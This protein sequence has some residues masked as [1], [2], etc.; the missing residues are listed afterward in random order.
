MDGHI[1]RRQPPDVTIRREH[2]TKM[3]IAEPAYDRDVWQKLWDVSVGL[4][5]LDAVR[6]PG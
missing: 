5:Q 3:R 6:L 4:T 2:S 1:H